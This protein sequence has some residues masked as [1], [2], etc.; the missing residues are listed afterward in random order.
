MKY[1]K[2]AGLA[3]FGLLL[4]FVA[5]DASASIINEGSG[6]TLHY[7]YGATAGGLDANT[8]HYWS[9]DEAGTP[10]ADA[11]SVVDL[12]PMASQTTTAS[13][14]SIL[15][16]AGGATNNARRIGTTGTGANRITA[17]ANTTNTLADNLS[18]AQANSFFGSNGAMTVDLLIRPDFSLSDTIGSV[19]R[20]INQE[21]DEVNP[22]NLFLGYDANA[23]AAGHL[24]EFGVGG[25]TLKMAVPTTGDHALVSGAWYHFAATYNGN[26]S[27][28]NNVKF[29][30]TRVN[31]PSDTTTAANLVST[32]TFTADPSILTLRPEFT[33]GNETNGTI[34]KSFFGAFD[35]IR[36][37]SIDRD[38]SG[39]GAG[40]IFV[41]EPSSIVLIGI[42]LMGLASVAGRRRG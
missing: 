17:F 31:G 2:I 12:I 40:F 34:N 1:E 10:F 20:I 36:I 19:M 37:S 27:G 22:Q 26:E 15:F 11:G 21:N 8:S 29:Y 16:S 38:P 14:S 32:D 24:I 25:P 5:R 7:G 6:A 18:V 33:F 13:V 41:P 28:T 9:L 23:N 30:W 3:A 39:T 4:A 42:S 35:E